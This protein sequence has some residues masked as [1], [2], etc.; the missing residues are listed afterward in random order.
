MFDRLT[1]AY[2]YG[3]KGTAIKINGTG[4]VTAEQGVAWVDALNRGESVQVQFVSPGAANV[5]YLQSK[6]GLTGGFASAYTSFGPTL[7]MNVYPT[8]GAPGGNILSTFLLSEGGYAVYSGTSMATPFVAATYALVQEVRKKSGNVGES[9]LATLLSSTSQAQL[10]NDGSGTLNDLA[11]VPQQGTGLVQAYAAAFTSTLLTT[12]S[13]SFNDTDHKPENMTFTLENTGSDTITYTLSNIPAI[14]M[15]VLYNDLQAY[16]PAY[17]PNPIFAASAG[18]NFSQDLVNLAPK[19]RA[20]ITVTASPPSSRFDGDNSL[21]DGLLPIYSGYIAIN[22]SNGDN[23]TIPY[24]GLAG[25]FYQADNIDPA[26]SSMLGCASEGHEY[27]CKTSNL[28]YSVPYP[29][30]PPGS[31]TGQD[32]GYSYPEASLTVDLGS[33]LIRADVIPLSTNYSSPTTTTT[34]T[35]VL[36]NKTAGS[37]YGF[38]RAYQ[39]RFDVVEV[40][41]TGMLADGTVV[42]AGE[43]ALAVR[44]LRLFGDPDEVGDYSTLKM[45][46]FTLEYTNTG[47]SSG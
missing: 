4:T 17:F 33:A 32:Y 1:E 21:S 26:K 38:P 47:S 3:S 8:V 18:L 35:T 36:G 37:V 25:S 23:V 29:T 27:E 5:V 44:A 12:Q 41:F 15:Y 10:W 20:L 11:P 34:T 31:T 19:E 40:V 28:T 22:G 2:L 9:D 7:G 46:P 14:G 30:A 43:Y 42:P 13:I 24:L 6:N 16:F 45:I 39:D